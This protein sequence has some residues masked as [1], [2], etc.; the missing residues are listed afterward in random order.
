MQTE[1]AAIVL[2]AGVGKRMKSSRSKVLHNIAGKP[3][4]VRTVETLKKLNLSQIVVVASPDNSKQLEEILGNGVTIAIQKEPLGTG[5]AANVGL[6]FLKKEV[7]DVAVLY[8]DDTAFYKP[9]IVSKV[10]K[11]HAQSKSEITFVTINVKSPFGL[12]RIVRDNNKIAIVEEKDA[13]DDQKKIKEVNDGL[14]V[15][16]KEFIE[17][18]IKNLNPS[19]ATGEL[20]LTDL[21]EMANDQGKKINTVTL[22]QEHW[23]GI[24]TQVELAQANFKHNKRIHIMGIS[25]AG[26]SAVAGITKAFEFEVSGC[27]KG[28]IS[29]YSENL[30]VKVENR[31]DPGHIDSDLP[32]LVISPAI[33]IA[34]PQNKE[35]QKAKDLGIPVLT[36]QEFQGNILQNDKFVIAVSGGYGKSTTTAM[37]CQILI[38]AGL[39][40]TCEVGAKVLG[41]KQN[42][43]VGGSKY[44]VCE[45]DEYNDNFL[46]YKPDIAVILNMSW[47]HP[48]YFKSKEDLID[49]YEKFI[50]NI[51][52]GGKLILGSD[53]T[54]NQT[55]KSLNFHKLG[56]DPQIITVK[57]FGNLSLS[58][59]GDFRKENANAAL[60]VA[61]VLKLDIEKAKRSVEKFKGLGRR[62]EYKGEINGIKFYDDYAVQPYTIEKT[63][64]AL[65]EKYKQDKVILILE[66]HMVS[67]VNKFFNKFVESL[68]NTKVDQILIT[69]TFLAR[70]KGNAKELSQK[71]A[72][73]VGNKAIYCGTVKEVVDYIKKN[74]NSFDV[75]CTM[76]AGDVYKIWDVAIQNG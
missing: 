76:G 51:K 20:Y 65:K 28:A 66:P 31:H 72:K 56:S 22:G 39:D 14:Y 41:W 75:V 52:P 25:G 10:F 18:N 21:I 49:S 44:Y 62:L 6:E 54:L 73:L 46:N 26:A 3:M 32:C 55:Q 61:S 50:S 59:I 16:K 5:D 70:E 17:N 12:G 35:L 36:W 64:N 11:E 53:P 34:D 2:A 45:A 33:E 1:K 7:T 8:G 24:N 4:I 47:D 42:F 29:P 58:I 69:D 27:D 63:A 71:L 15:F 13:S 38:D 30:D 48:D 9:E 19:K 67:R 74:I 68:K 23:H 40:P 57:D 43:R 37:I 60:T